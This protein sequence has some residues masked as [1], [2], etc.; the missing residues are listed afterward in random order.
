[1]LVFPSLFLL[2][3][4]PLLLLLLCC[5]HYCKCV[6]LKRCSARQ[7]AEID[8]A[9]SKVSWRWLTMAQRAHACCVGCVSIC[10]H[11]GACASLCVHLRFLALGFVCLRYFRDFFNDN[12]IG[13]SEKDRRYRLAGQGNLR[14]A[15]PVLLPHSHTL[16]CKHLLNKLPKAAVLFFCSRAGPHG[17]AHPDQ[18]AAS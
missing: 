4:H 13:N 3:L 2:N 1:M 17:L 15:V 8:Q 14:A 7:F 5:L 18:S 9:A 16:L 6:T 11:G 12:C 10:W